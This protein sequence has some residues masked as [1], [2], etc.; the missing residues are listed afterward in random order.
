MPFEQPQIYAMESGHTIHYDRTKFSPDHTRHMTAGYNFIQYTSDAGG[1]V[2]VG[3]RLD[4][5]NPLIGDRVKIVQV[6][7]SKYG[8]PTGNITIG[9]RKASDDSLVTIGTYDIA[10]VVAGRGEFSFSVR[11]RGNTY[12]C[13]VNDVV[14]VEY[15]PAA[16]A[17]DGLN[18]LT[19]QALAN[20]SL[21]T[22]RQYNG[23]SWSNTTQAPAMLIKGANV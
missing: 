16:S 13:L 4:A 7:V 8:N 21:W 14:S 19:N 3:A 5:T 1:I 12:D 23:T 2:R 20:Q 18:I 11:N 6:F 22:G 15:T 17:S 9:V 10:N